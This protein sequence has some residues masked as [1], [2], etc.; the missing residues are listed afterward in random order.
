MKQKYSINRDFEAKS[1]IIKEFAEMEK[2]I[3]SL[4]C[5][6]KYEDKAI[7]SAMEKGKDALIKVL[8]TQNLYPPTSHINRIAESVISL[9]ESNSD[10]PLEICFDD[11]DTLKKRRTHRSLADDI[12]NDPA[13][14]GD[15]LEDLDDDFEE[16]GAIK[17]INSPL[18]V[19][20]DDMIDIGDDS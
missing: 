11:I 17:N 8:R 14:I 16:K 15:L 18:N 6:A 7:K 12:D 9:Y 3:V 13:E 20:E 5:E 19:A 1:L 10:Q 2:E 4:L